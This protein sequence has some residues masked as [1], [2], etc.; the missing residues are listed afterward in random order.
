MITEKDLKEIN[1][2]LEGIKQARKLNIKAKSKVNL[3][4]GSEALIYHLGQANKTIRIDIK[5][6]SNE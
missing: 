6:I 5:E 3:E 1:K 2:N 4:D